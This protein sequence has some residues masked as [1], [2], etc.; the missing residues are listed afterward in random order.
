MRIL[1]FK[2][3]TGEMDWLVERDCDVEDYD[4]DELLQRKKEM[5]IEIF[6]EAREG[7]ISLLSFS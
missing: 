4:E 2:F 6:K 3:L 5:M 1:T 7:G